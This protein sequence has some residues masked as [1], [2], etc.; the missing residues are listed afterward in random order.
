MNSVVI[1]NTVTAL[2]TTRAKVSKALGVYIN[3]RV[4]L[5]WEVTICQLT[6]TQKGWAKFNSII[7]H[8]LKNG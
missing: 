1:V 5:W 7:T 8:E 4:L 2:W 6:C 3:E